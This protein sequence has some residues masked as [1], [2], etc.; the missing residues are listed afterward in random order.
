MDA[1]WESKFSHWA[2]PP[3]ESENDRVVNTVRAIRKALDSGDPLLESTKIYLQGSYRNNVNI[4]SNSDVDIGV[5]YTGDTFFAEYPDGMSN[6]DFGNIESKLS[7]N[8]FRATVKE[9]LLDYFGRSV[10]T[11]G[12]KSL[13]I[14]DNSYR[15]DADVVPV[16]VHRRYRNDGTFQNGVQFTSQNGT[17]VI[18]W[19]ERIYDSPEWPDQHYENGVRKNT[20]TGRRYKRTVRILKKLKIE[21]IEQRI[22]DSETISSFAIEC[23]AWNTPNER[24]DAS[25]WDDTLQM[26]LRFLW[27]N[28]RDDEPCS[29]WGEVSDLKYLF[30]GSPV[31]KRKNAHNFV[32]KAWDYIGV[33]SE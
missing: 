12:N 3:S 2:S 16:L 25:S 8:H 26:V 32:D 17:K 31:S 9:A 13:K 29:E 24:F 1:D 22:I 21:L 15:V 10:V 30:R 6:S 11:S 27:Q 18:N 7:Y 33:R 20:E 28:T 5:L 4:R 23:M 14:N 19:P